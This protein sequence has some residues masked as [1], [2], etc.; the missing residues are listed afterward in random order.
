MPTKF[1]KG[2]RAGL[3]GRAVFIGNGVGVRTGRGVW[4]TEPSDAPSTTL[5]IARIF[6][7]G[8]GN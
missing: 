6:V 8:A 5:L 4:V 1:G 2:T 7:P 3:T